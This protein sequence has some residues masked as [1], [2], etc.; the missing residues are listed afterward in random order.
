MKK[1]K[2][3]KHSAVNAR[4]L[5]LFFC[6]LLP[7][8]F[9]PFSASADAEESMSSYDAALYEEQKEA[10]GADRLIEAAPES[11]REILQTLGLDA[12]DPETLLNL[13]LGEVLS[14]LC[15]A[16]LSRLSA[17]GLALCQI[18]AAV[19][20]GAFLSVFVDGRDHAQ[21]QVFALVQTLFLGA[22]LL[23]N[24]ASCADSVIGLVHTSAR[25][26]LTYVPIYAACTALSGHTLAASACHLSFFGVI[27]GVGAVLPVILTPLL[28]ALLAFGV[29]AS[30]GDETLGRV[31]GLLQKV[32]VWVLGIASTVVSALLSIQTLI[33]QS[34][35]NVLSKTAKY[36]ISAAVP[37]VGGVLSDAL[38]A[39]KGSAGVLKAGVGVLGLLIVLA[40]FLP[41]LLELLCWS[42]CLCLGEWT[43]E[44]F[45]QKPV[46][47][48]LG[49][50]RAVVR[51]L[52]ALLLCMLLLVALSTL[53]LMAAGRTG[54]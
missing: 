1:G 45:G 33:T 8:F 41:P 29:V 23:P 16:V 49:G 28:Y 44:L 25:F 4:F 51:I 42:V 47:A 46:G 20:F 24:L 53:I 36:V 52:I 32:A 11:A 3:Y 43:A 54:S 14:A 5:F 38:L 22:A 50:G 10:T 40:A 12:L 9:L 21:E 19:L 7:T 30:I 31:A 6:L 48:V 18:L 15:N 13:N 27:E 34:A 35:E 37:F 2:T 26:M 17:P 39:V